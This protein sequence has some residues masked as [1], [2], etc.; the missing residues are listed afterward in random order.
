MT[1]RDPGLETRELLAAGLRELSLG[2]AEP[3]LELLWKLAQ[4]LEKWSKR[5]NLSGHRTADQIV[6]RLILDAAA[7]VAELP[8]VPTLADVGSGAGFPGFPIA[9]LRPGCQVALIESR[10]RRH[11]FQREVIRQLGLSNATAVLG[12]AETLEPAPCAAAIGQAVA[13]PFDLLPLLL[14]WTE[15]GGLLLFPG[16]AELAAV[17]DDPRVRFESSARYRVPC[18]GPERTLWIARRV[19][20]H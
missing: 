4:L 18:G 5:I 15:S 10:S 19:S 13:R 7:L 8:E 9:I 16:G 6:R 17:P 3:Q 2:V 12:R 11:H 20:P 14:P 1:G